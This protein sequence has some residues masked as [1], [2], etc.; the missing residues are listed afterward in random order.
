MFSPYRG[1]NHTKKLKKLKPKTSYTKVGEA[2]RQKSQYQHAIT[3]N[4]QQCAA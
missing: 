2:T 4:Q 3:T 1:R